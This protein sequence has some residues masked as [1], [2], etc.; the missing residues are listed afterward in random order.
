M[1]VGCDNFRPRV[2]SKFFQ[3]ALELGSTAELLVRMSFL[4]TEL[5]QAQ[6]ARQWNRMKR[7]TEN[8]KI[9]SVEVKIQRKAKIHQ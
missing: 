4:D 9:S 6:F 3:I 5:S 2:M 7:G 8:G 1:V